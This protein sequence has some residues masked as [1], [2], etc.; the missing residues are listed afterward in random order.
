MEKAKKASAP[1]ALNPPVPG[2][3]A[4][5]PV[6]FSNRDVRT[7]MEKFLYTK[8]R[9]RVILA[10]RAVGNAAVLVPGAA[11]VLI[12]GGARAAGC[13]GESIRPR[14]ETDRTRS[15]DVYGPAR[16]GTDRS[17]PLRG[18]PRHFPGILPRDESHAV[19]IKDRSSHQVR[20]GVTEPPAGETGPRGRRTSF[21]CRALFRRVLPSRPGKRGFS[22]HTYFEKGDLDLWQKN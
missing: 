12:V 10:Q 8:S 13:F 1:T 21:L 16:A 2:A 9:S 11:W 6:G 19:E 15:M 4:R 20:L 5:F 22:L 14:P 3:K 17:C 7:G 18:R